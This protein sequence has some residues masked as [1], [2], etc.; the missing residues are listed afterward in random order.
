[1]SDECSVCCEVVYCSVFTAGTAG[2]RR[3]PA[4]CTLAFGFM[5]NIGPLLIKLKLL[6]PLLLLLLF[7]LLQLA[8]RSR[9][10][11]RL[12][13]CA[14]AKPPAPQHASNLTSALNRKTVPQTCR[15]LC[16]LPM[17][18]S[19]WSKACSAQAARTPLQLQ[20]ANYGGCIFAV[21]EAFGAALCCV[22]ARAR[23][24]GPLAVGLTRDA[25]CFVWCRCVVQLNVVVAV[26]EGW[27]AGG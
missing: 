3:R 17:G 16:T 7:L 25:D 22:A 5:C 26:G 1:M 18:N 6:L 14:W 11:P 15:H 19:Y 12:L 13:T 21:S 20:Q 24:A 2:V 9:H 10:G 27:W 23:S 4:D 8:C